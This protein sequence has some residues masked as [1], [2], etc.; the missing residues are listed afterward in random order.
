MQAVEEVTLGDASFSA[1]PALTERWLGCSV[2][3]LL[4][5]G[6]AWNREVHQ[7]CFIISVQAL[8]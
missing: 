4:P 2:E 1:F 6:N 5:F 3:L 7:E 8:V